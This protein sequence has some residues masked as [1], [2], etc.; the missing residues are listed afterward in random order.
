MTASGADQAS[1]QETGVVAGKIAQYLEGAFD[2]VRLTR[3]EHFTKN[4]GKR[5]SRGDIDRIIASYA[6]QNAVIAAA[7]NLVPGPWG[8]LT[9]VP[10]ITLVIRNQIQMIYDLG[11]AYGQE[12]HLT[13]DTLLAVFAT[14]MGGGAV[15]LAAV[16]GGQL[17]VKRASL[18]VIQQVIKWL[19]G[20]IAQRVL[21]AFLAKWVPI[22]GA[23]AMGIWARQSTRA[24]GKRAAELLEKEIVF[25]E[26]AGS[27][28][29]AGT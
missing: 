16:K 17:I 22:A 4:P 13:R 26:G 1:T 9:I 2:S 29:P 24:M 15:S 8:A 5:P 6:N 23:A 3:Q 20:K 14:V 25:E 7:A 18:R 12:A 11:V 27:S 28:A 10:E 21:R 19:G